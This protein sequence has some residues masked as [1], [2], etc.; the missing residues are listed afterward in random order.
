MHVCHFAFKVPEAL[1]KVDIAESEYVASI[2]AVNGYTTEF[3]PE[4]EGK[5][6]QLQVGELARGSG[7]QRILRDLSPV[8]GL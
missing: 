7:T 4:L 6:N 3:Q 8:P 1:R 5:L 2:M